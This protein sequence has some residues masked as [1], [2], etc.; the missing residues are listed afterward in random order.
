MSN[1]SVCVLFI[2]QLRHTARKVNKNRTYAE[3]NQPE[4]TK[5]QSVYSDLCSSVVVYLLTKHIVLRIQESKHSAERLGGT[6][7]SIGWTKEHNMPL[8]RKLSD[9]TTTNY[10]AE[11]PMDFS[12]SIFWLSILSWF[13]S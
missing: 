7:N 3:P 2:G 13:I 10:L 8:D 5:T 1:D 4:T 12:K 9:Y 11:R 6:A